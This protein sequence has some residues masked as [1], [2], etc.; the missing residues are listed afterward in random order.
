MEDKI[1][2]RKEQLD[3]V[4]GGTD[5]GY[6][7]SGRKCP[8]CGSKRVKFIGEECDMGKFECGDCGCTFFG[9]V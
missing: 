3:Q 6:D 9:D 5:G 1:I 7:Q 8:K 4:S 2:I